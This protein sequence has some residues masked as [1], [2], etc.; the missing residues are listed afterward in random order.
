MSSHCLAHSTDGRRHRNT[1]RPGQSWLPCP[2]VPNTY[3]HPVGLGFSEGTVPG[4]WFEPTKAP[5][6]QSP[7]TI[8]AN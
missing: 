5:I 3:H 7:L 2:S 4:V 1:H 6:G 8:P